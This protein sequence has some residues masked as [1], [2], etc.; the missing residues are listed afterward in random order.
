[1]NPSIAAGNGE[2]TSILVADD[3]TLGTAA[4]L[5]VVKDTDQVI[6]K[7]PIVIGES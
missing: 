2:K 5:V 4:F 6:F 1:V 7:H 3:D